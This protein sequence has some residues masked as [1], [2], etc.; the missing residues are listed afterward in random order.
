VSKEDQ[1]LMDSITLY[2]YFFQSILIH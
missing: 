1:E 2:G